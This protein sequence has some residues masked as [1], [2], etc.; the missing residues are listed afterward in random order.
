M[1][2]HPERGSV[3]EVTCPCC[4]A[5]LTVAPAQGTVIGREMG[6]HAGTG[7]DLKDA[8]RVLEQESAR[9]HDRYD[10]IVRTEKG[11]GAALDKLFKSHMEKSKDKPVS[12]PVR[13]IDL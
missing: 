6:A 5:R 9:I 10:E 8:Q 7:V 1:P 2:D 12:P 13:E 4:D 11:R 3:I